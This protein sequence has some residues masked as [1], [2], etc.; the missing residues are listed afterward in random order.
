MYKTILTIVAIMVAVFMIA[1]SGEKKAETEMEMKPETKTAVEDTS[2]MATCPACSMV[3]DKSEMTAYD[4]DGD[5][6]YFCS[7]GCQKHYLAQQ[8]SKESE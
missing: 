3:K 5:T 8:K 1:C 7:E 4:A 6:L 2:S